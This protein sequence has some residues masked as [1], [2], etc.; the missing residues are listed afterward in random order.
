MIQEFDIDQSGYVSVEE[1]VHAARLF[2]NYK[3]V[4]KRLGAIL[5]VLLAVLCTVCGVMGGVVYAVVHLSRTTG[6]QG[7][8]TE[9]ACLWALCVCMY[10]YS[11]Q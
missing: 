6:E 4:Y 2:R 11:E 5:A 8:M 7:I 9:C 3:N 10:I 1:L